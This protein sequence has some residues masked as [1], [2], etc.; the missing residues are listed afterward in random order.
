LA[1]IDGATALGQLADDAV[2]TLT[3]WQGTR[4]LSPDD[5]ATLHLLAGWLDRATAILSDP[6]GLVLKPGGVETLPGL[7]TFSAGVAD[8]AHQAVAAGMTGERE[9]SA[10]QNFR[11]KLLKVLD[12]TAEPEVSEQLVVTFEA[13]AN[14]MLAV[15]DS[16]LAPQSRSAWV[17]TSTF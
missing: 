10:I 3:S 13:I 7:D 2:L 9:I 5:E 8:A 11:S 17:T 16:M 14:A 6:V 15:A 12:G 4:Q 1:S